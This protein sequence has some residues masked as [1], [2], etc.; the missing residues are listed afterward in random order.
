MIRVLLILILYILYKINLL[1]KL[2][3]TSLP[4][5]FGFVLA[6]IVSPLVYK[7][8][9]KL[10]KIISISIIIILLVLFIFILL[11][12]IIPLFIK[13]SSN[14]YNLFILVSSRFNI[15]IDKLNN[16]LN[17]QNILNG[18]SLS[19]NVITNILITFISFIYILIDMDKIKEFIKNINIKL[20]NY[21]SYISK[22]LRIY[23]SSLIRISII[24][25][26]E[27]TIAFLLIRYPNPILI[28]LLSGILNM[29][30]YLGGMLTILITIILAPSMIIPISILYIILGLIDGYIISPYVYGKYNKVNPILGLLALSIG[31]IFGPI[32]VVLSYPV[33]IIILSSIRYLNSW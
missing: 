8:N 27:Y 1:G 33:L 20:Y 14:I 7:L 24:S 29:I 32:G 21:L 9:K 10:S 4:F 18:I 13:E 12:I 31:G 19:L 6:Y 5:I 17:Y 15:N 25:F 23:I 2:V 3:S 11:Y 28:G 16:I 26:F 22:D 30:P